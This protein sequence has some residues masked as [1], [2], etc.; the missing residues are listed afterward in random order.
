[1]SLNNWGEGGGRARGRERQ[2]DAQRDRQRPGFKNVQLMILHKS[3]LCLPFLSKVGQVMNRIY[4][5]FSS[6]W[7]EFIIRNL[8]AVSLLCDVNWLKWGWTCQHYAWNIADSKCSMDWPEV[9]SPRLCSGGWLHLSG[10]PTVC[11]THD[12]PWSFSLNPWK[13]N[14]FL[15]FSRIR[16]S[17]LRRKRI[18]SRYFLRCSRF[19]FHLPPSVVFLVKTVDE[20]NG[21]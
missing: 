10:T 13:T 5:L 18:V 16:K 11:E 9:M 8:G 6:P 17:S 19:S 1:M 14:F 7:A 2:R 3:S 20:A 21:P 15:S 4:I 12:F